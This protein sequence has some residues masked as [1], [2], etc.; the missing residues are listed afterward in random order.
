MPCGCPR[1]AQGVTPRARTAP[2]PGTM[3][4]VSDELTAPVAA[5]DVLELTVGEAVHGGSCVARPDETGTAGHGPGPVL[6][7]RHALPGE[8]VRAV[9]TQTTSRFARA[10]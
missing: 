7:V 5:G 4:G 6:F 8:R 9:V 2:A 3:V 10:D 1:L